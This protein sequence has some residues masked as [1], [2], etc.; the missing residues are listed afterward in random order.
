MNTAN[1]HY[2]FMRNLLLFLA[3]LS[4]YGCKDT[5]LDIADILAEKDKNKTA[6]VEILKDTYL[7]TTK[8]YYSLDSNLLHTKTEVSHLKLDLLNETGVLTTTEPEE[9]VKNKSEQLYEEKWGKIKKILGTGVDINED[10]ALVENLTKT[11]N[12]TI[13]E[14]NSKPQESQTD[15]SFFVAKDGGILRTMTPQQ[16]NE[17]Q[18][19]DFRLLRK[20]GAITLKLDT[21]NDEVNSPIFEY[22]T[23]E[24]EKKLIAD[25]LEIIATSSSQSDLN[26]NLIDFPIN[27]SFSLKDSIYYLD[28]AGKVKLEQ[29]AYLGLKAGIIDGEK[30]STTGDIPREMAIVKNK[31]YN[32]LIFTSKDALDTFTYLPFTISQEGETIVLTAELKNN[33]KDLPI[34][35]IPNP[36]NENI[37]ESTGIDPT[38]EYASKVILR[39]RLSKN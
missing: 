26:T 19:Y 16:K 37:E 1:T 17:E 27:G 21:T 35:E 6:V 12:E 9:K 32:T 4:L 10:Y 3:A 30:L 25:K 33:N 31:G 23:S 11:I 34:F 36:D 29:E 20:D 28:K 14:L 38:I 24:N 18:Y 39:I 7:N 5:S 8:N 2:H 15:F 22:E 13:I